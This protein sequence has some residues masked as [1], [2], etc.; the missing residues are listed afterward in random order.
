MPGVIAAEL[1]DHIE[2]DQLHRDFVRRVAKVRAAPFQV[3]WQ[4]H[5]HQLE[6]EDLDG[7]VLL[8]WGDL[9]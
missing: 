9:P 4:A 1:F 2:L 5:V 3:S 8:F 6:V 7:N